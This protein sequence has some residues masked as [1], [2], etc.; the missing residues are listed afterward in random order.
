MIFSD[1]FY[2]Q[3]LQSKNTFSMLATKAKRISF[4]VS[5]DSFHEI[6][7]KFENFML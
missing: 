3:H 1:V 6:E 5:K 7:K 4:E 2:R